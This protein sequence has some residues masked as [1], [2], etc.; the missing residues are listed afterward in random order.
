MIYLWEF[1]EKSESK[2]E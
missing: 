1:L 2:S